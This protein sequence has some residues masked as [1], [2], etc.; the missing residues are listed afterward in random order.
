MHDKI[1][2][3][4]FWFYNIAINTL[5]NSWKATFVDAQPKRA[6]TV[7][8][9]GVLNIFNIRHKNRNYLL[10]NDDK[11]DREEDVEEGDNGRNKDDYTQD[12]MQ[13]I[14][15]GLYKKVRNLCNHILG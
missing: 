14:L 12:I 7:E 15:Y 1:K 6:M 9:S 11:D 10:H 4:I 2:E 5:L 8:K 13:L 3:Y